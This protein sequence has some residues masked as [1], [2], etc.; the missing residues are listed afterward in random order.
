MVQAKETARD[1]D[2][3]TLLLRT[4]CVFWLIAKLI[5]WRI[6]TTVRLLPTAPVWERFDVVPGIVHTVLFAVSLLLIPLLI[7]K[8]NRWILIGLLVNET[9]L[10]ML[11]Q[12]RLQFWEYEYM[13]IV[14]IFI[15][16]F[17]NPRYIKAPI[18][19]L[20]AGMH[21]YS[22]VNKLNDSFLQTIWAD[23][24]ARFLSIDVRAHHLHWLYYCGYLAGITEFMAGA[25]LLFVKTQARAAFFLIAMHV[26]ILFVFGPLGYNINIVIWPWNVGIICTLYIIFF[27]GSERLVNVEHVVLGWNK[28][29]IL[30][31]GILPALSFLGCWDKNLSANLISGR[32]PRMIICVNDTSNC[33]P[34]QKFCFKK[35][36]SNTCKGLPKINLLNWVLAEDNVIVYAE[37]RVFNIIQQK[38]EKQYPAA[39]LSF[40]YFDRANEK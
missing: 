17:R 24:L 19:F 32:L 26:L 9:L 30:F 13:F 4:A 14:F 21:F 25:G 10:C 11:D 8:N 16:N 5:S 20:L 39:G 23:S 15:L 37:P 38:L 29:I 7:L 3:N 12:M 2:T 22:G 35:D 28:A 27:R 36:G 33:K 6:W 1:S 40:T 18:V 31:W 34:L